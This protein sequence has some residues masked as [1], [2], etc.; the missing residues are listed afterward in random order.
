MAKD[1]NI[2]RRTGRCRLC[3]KELLP[4]DVFVATV[5][6]C[7][8]QF[9]RFD[10]CEACWQD[11]RQEQSDPDLFGVWHTCVPQAE[12]K[13]KLFVDEECLVEFFERLDGAG[14]PAKVNF[15][16]VLALVLMRKKL[17]VYDRMEKQ[18]DG[19]EIWH[20]HLKGDE[21]DHQ[22]TDPHMDEEKIAEVSRSL[23]EILEGE[24]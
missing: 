16:F 4:G 12:E 11:R 22:V 8:E 14:Q 23:G 15:R 3:E 17:L 24:L 20:M 9:E 1:Y 5:R 21:T 7:G 19:R 6:A 10:F 18:P 2:S 13:R